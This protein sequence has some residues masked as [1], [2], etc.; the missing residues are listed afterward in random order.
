MADFTLVFNDDKTRKNMNI[1]E[2]ILNLPEMPK[3]RDPKDLEVSTIVP[4]KSQINTSVA[5]DKLRQKIIKD[6]LEDESLSSDET[7]STASI[8][9]ITEAKDED[10]PLPKKEEVIN[11]DDDFSEM[12]DIDDKRRHRDESDKERAL[13]RAMIIELSH[14]EHKG[15][16]VRHLTYK[17]SIDEIETEL[18]KARDQVKFKVKIKFFRFMIYAFAWITEKVLVR[19]GYGAEIEGWANHVRQEIKEYDQFFEEMV[20]P[21]YIHQTDGTIVRVENKSFIN[22]ITSNSEANLFGSLAISAI[23]YMAA[24]KFVQFSAILP[25]DASRKI[26][27]KRRRRKEVSVS[28]SSSSA[29]ETEEPVSQPETE[30]KFSFLEQKS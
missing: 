3:P 27:R 2:D 19:I 17:N 1:G 29:S 26:R 30:P 8:S 15:C 20:R 21:Q 25:D 7:S 16:T 6:K 28:E 14:L 9:T 23:F 10:K 18:E 5:R 24:N 13:K 11:L 4:G 12:S 22:R